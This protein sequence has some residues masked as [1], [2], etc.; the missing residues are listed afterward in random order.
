[1]KITKAILAS[2]FALIII[3]LPVLALLGAVFLLPPQY[4]NTFVGGLDEKYE[5]LTGI[6]EPKIVIVGG[7]SVAF[8]IE[9]ALI[10][11]YIGMPVVNFGLYAALGTKV[12]LDLSRAG[13]NEG[14]VVIL[15]PELDKQTM[16]MYFNAET[17]LQATDDKPEI[18]KHLRG[19]DI[20][21]T[22]GALFD[23]V[24][25]KINYFLNGAPNPSGVYNSKSF[26]EWGDI[27]YPRDE[28]TMP[29]TYDPNTPIDLS[30]NILSEDFIEYLNA[31]V[32]FCEGRGASVYF[33]FCP[34]NEL[35]LTE[36]TT[37]ESM[38]AFESLLDD[39]LSCRMISD[40]EDYVLGAGYFYDTN[41]HLNDVGARYRTLRLIEDIQIERDINT[42]VVEEYPDEPRLDNDMIVIPP[43]DG[44]TDGEGG[45]ENPPTGGENDN[46]GTTEKP[47]TPEPLDPT[48]TENTEYFNYEVLSSGNLRIV[49][50]TDAGK[51]QVS[52]TVPVYAKLEGDTVRRAVTVLGENALAGSVAE[53]L[54]IPENS[55]LGSFANGCFTGASAL[56]R[57]Y[58]YLFDADSL[59]P[60]KSFSGTH[61]DFLIHAPEGS[62]Y[63]TSYYW[64]QVRG[65][66]IILDLKVY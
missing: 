57:L 29:L 52:L 38:K 37:E 17:T 49:S 35:A 62:D 44:E 19:D 34:M 25:A 53:E 31:Y 11:K 12:M 9:S 60:P 5:R 22:L 18:L 45:T 58:I 26:N 4:S 54:I 33:S 24:G 64:S 43:M 46:T 15:A 39:K 16:S 36:G 23:H 10:E 66:E 8:G 7:S 6:T 28:N 50:L 61:P 3:L 30:E 21:A 41:F 59:N 42:L 55:Y 20:F 51:A 63:T 1:M 2:V 14:D 32:A 27:S 40:I 13:I 47:D 65:V 48:L 56:Q